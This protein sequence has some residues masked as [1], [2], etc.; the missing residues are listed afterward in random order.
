MYFYYS[1]KKAAWHALYGT[2]VKVGAWAMA[3]IA[4]YAL[5]DDTIIASN[6]YSGATLF[7]ELTFYVAGALFAVGAWQLRNDDR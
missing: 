4:L 6:R 2:F 3:I 1:G 5:I 7:F